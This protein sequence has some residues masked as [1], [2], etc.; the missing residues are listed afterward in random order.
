[1][2]RICHTLFH[3]QPDVGGKAGPL[4]L[5]LFGPSSSGGGSGS[6]ATAQMLRLGLSARSKLSDSDKSDSR[7]ARRPAS[8][9]TPPA[10]PHAG[11][12]AG[13]TADSG[14]ADRLQ[15]LPY[16]G[17]G[18]KPLMPYQNVGTLHPSGPFSYL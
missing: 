5:Q 9:A 13:D 15:S 12:S 14:A 18:R 8:A 3:I 16:L 4:P 7:A 17:K 2:F 10:P 1:M 11:D 6:M